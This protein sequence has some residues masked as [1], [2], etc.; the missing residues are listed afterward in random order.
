MRQDLQPTPLQSNFSSGERMG[1]E[2]ALLC[3]TS[4]LVTTNKE[5]IQE[6]VLHTRIWKG[7]SNFSLLYLPTQERL[8]INGSLC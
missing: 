7:Q 8:R 4:T 3:L 2:I 1:E 6:A 5:E